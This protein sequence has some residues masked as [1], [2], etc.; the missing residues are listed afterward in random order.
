MSV[1]SIEIT[2]ENLLSAVAQ[3]PEQEFEQFI[4]KANALRQKSLIGK[5]SRK[6]SELIL[7]INTLFPI[8]KREKYN[9]LYKKF[10]ETKLT[11]TEYQELLELNEEFEI[12]NAKRL[13]YIGELAKLRGQTIEEVIEDLQIKV[14]KL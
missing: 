9:K 3:M 5:K 6:E 11:E 1:H 2:T 7:K 14:S 10:R 8:D 13:K 12:L 4:K